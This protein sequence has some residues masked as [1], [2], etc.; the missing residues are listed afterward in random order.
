MATRL[1]VGRIG[2]VGEGRWR[3]GFFSGVAT[4]CMKLF[5]LVGADRAYFG[6]KD[7]QQLAVIRQIVADLDLPLEIVACPTVR[8]ADGLAASSRNRCL[9]AGARRAATALPRALLAAG[10][11]AASGERSARGLRRMVKA[12][13]LGEPGLKL[14][15]AEVFDAET[16]EPVSE[17]RRP[18][19]L[20]AAAFAGDVRLIDNVELRQEEEGGRA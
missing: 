19:V 10:E 20:A 14:Q 17:I 9:D 6:R 13:L 18:A 12:G 1:E 16:F 5:H 15:Y 3:P 11:A 7:F 2:D 8:E 4:V